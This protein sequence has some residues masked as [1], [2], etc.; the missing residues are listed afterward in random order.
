VRVPG[1]E[2]DRP[3]PIEVDGQGYQLAAWVDAYVAHHRH[4][5]RHRELLAAHCPQS[6][7]A[8][9]TRQQI[10]QAVAS[11]AR[12]GWLLN[13]NQWHRTRPGPAYLAQLAREQQTATAPQPAAPADPPR[14]G[15]WLIPGA[16]TILGPPR[17]ETAHSPTPRR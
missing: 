9:W 7:T 1:S 16:D 17:Q 14:T 12:E 2:P 15:L 6:P 8:P 5:P 10:Q 3:T 13:S 11:L 4:G